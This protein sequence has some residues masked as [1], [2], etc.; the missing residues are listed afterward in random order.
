MSEQTKQQP[1]G[2]KVLPSILNLVNTV[3]G[4]GVLGLPYAFYRAGLVLALLMFFL[5]VFVSML[6]FNF[7]VDVCDSTLIYSFGDV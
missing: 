5:M 7:M 4:A 1:H 2:A 3:I 6:T